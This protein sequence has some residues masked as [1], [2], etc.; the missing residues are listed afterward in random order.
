MD[1]AVAAR[2]ILILSAE[3]VAAVLTLS[4]ALIH[5]IKG[6]IN[7]SL[8]AAAIFLLGFGLAAR[9]LIN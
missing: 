3:I 5:H 9:N 7:I 8:F 1:E 2:V 4:A 6:E